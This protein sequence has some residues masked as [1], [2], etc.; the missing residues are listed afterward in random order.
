MAPKPVRI[1]TVYEFSD[2][3][4]DCTDQNLS[5][6]GDPG[7]RGRLCA[8]SRDDA[9]TFVKKQLTTNPKAER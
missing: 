5:L 7:D 6:S 4:F 8:G 2:G 9:I 3:S 1:I